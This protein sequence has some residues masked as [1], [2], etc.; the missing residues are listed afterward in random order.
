[1]QC[2]NYW[3]AL[4]ISPSLAIGGWNTVKSYLFVGYGT[5]LGAKF[6]DPSDVSPPNV[7]DLP[8][9]WGHEDNR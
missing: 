2:I 5:V 1:M 9:W 6:E 4:G 8:V 3:V 7:E